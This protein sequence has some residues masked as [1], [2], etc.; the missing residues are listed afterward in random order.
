MRRQVHETIAKVSDDIG[1]RYTFNTAIAAVM[2]LINNVNRL[3]DNSPQGRA[4]IQ[5][6]LDSVVLVLSPIVPHIC[7]ALWYALGHQTAVV[8]AVWPVEDPRAMVRESVDLV[9][10]IN[11]KKRAQVSVSASAGQRE[12][13]QEALADANVKRFM[14]EKPAKKII[15]VPGK[16]VNI[17]V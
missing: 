3:E 11:G 16:L 2:E 14:A 4:V 12:I 8:E 15:V 1:R 10:Q 7:H 9:V 6:A 13:E 5:E 17:V